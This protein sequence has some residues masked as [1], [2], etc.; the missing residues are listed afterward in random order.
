MRILIAGCGYVGSELARLL[1]ADGHEVFGLRRD[2]SKLPEGILPVAADL[3]DPATL[4]KLPANID[5]VFYAASA[6]GYGEAPYR[7]A[8]VDSVTNVLS[9]LKGQHVRRIFFASSTG[10]YAQNDGEWVDEA[11]PATADRPTA[12]ALRDGEALIR[13]ADIPG[14]V[15]RFSGI[16]GPD[17]TRLIDSVVSG[18]AQRERG[19]TRYLNHIHR[20]DCAACLAHLM[21]VEN[22]A[23]LYLA[24]DNEPRTRN[25]FL[26]WIADATGSPVPPYADESQDTSRPSERGGN[27]RYRNDLLRSTGYTFKYPTFREGYGAL[28]AARDGTRKP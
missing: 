5:V 16:Y 27:R 2:T 6:N 18:S 23:A 8:Y 10:V 14:T 12:Q 21:T 24:T 19:E 20:D 26:E 9:A 3:N 15:V 25:E 4:A 13:N 1:Y 28:I 11:S 7:A 22:P 17:R